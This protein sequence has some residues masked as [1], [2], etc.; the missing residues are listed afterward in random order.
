MNEVGGMDHSPLYKSADAPVAVSSSRMPREIWL[1][2]GLVVIVA[3]GLV[4]VTYSSRGSLDT[5]GWALVAGASILTIIIALGSSLILKR[6]V[7]KGLPLETIFAEHSR[8]FMITQA[9]RP[10]A[11]N[12]SYLALFGDA[13]SNTAQSQDVI[14]L[15]DD[16]INLETDVVE[17]ELFRL[18]NLRDDSA[19]DE[20]TFSRQ[21]PSG[22]M[23]KFQLRVSGLGNSKLWEVI[24][25]VES[26]AADALF[27]AAP[28][29]LMSVSSNGEILTMN[30]A[31]ETWV[32]HDLS[33][34]RLVSDILEVD[35]NLFTPDTAVSGQ[36]MRAETHLK[37]SNGTS[38]P[39]VLQAR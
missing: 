4:Y 30:T 5:T 35:K 23:Q 3:L 29:G 9:G 27:E 32:G 20:A 18:H 7:P 13:V 12:K 28:V 1:M 39:I 21:T 26:E 16:L 37:T 31:L 11:A 17:R 33:D 22:D 38:I 10:V 2:L 6:D 36:K 8:P 25:T 24:D 34:A 15:L 14:P 19:S